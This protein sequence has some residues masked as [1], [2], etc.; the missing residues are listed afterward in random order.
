MNIQEKILRYIE[1]TRNK[2]GTVEELAREL[3]ID[4]SQI[5]DFNDIISKMEKDGRLI[6]TKKG[7]LATPKRLGLILGKLQTNPK[8][9]G[10]L[11]PEDEE[12]K[13][14]GDIFI[15]PDYL[16]GAMNGDKVAVWLLMESTGE[17]RSGEVASIFEHANRKVVGKYQASQNF[18]FVVPL[19]RRLFQDIFI[20]KKNGE[21]I[22]NGQLVEVL[23]TKWGYMNKSP[24]GKIVDV[25]GYEWEPGV[26]MKTV[27]KKYELEEDFP[28]K[29]LE[30]ANAITEDI[31][32]REIARRKDLRDMTLFTID[33]ADA[34]DFDDAVSIKKL[35][36]GNYE[37]GVHIADV[38]HYVKYNSPLD[39]EALDRG[40]SVYLVDRVIPMLPKRLSN[41]VCSLNPNVDRLALTVFME[42]DDKG[43]VKGH[44]IHES[45]INSKERLV[46]DDISDILENDDQ[47]QK[48]RYKHILDDLYAM[49]ELAKILMKRRE[50]RGSIGFDF[51]EAQ[52]DIDEDGKP[53]DIYELERRTANKLIEEFML[54]TNETV[55]EYMYWTETPFLYR[56]HEQPDEEKIEALNRFI[57]NF[58]YR[59]KTTKDI[60][61]REMQILIDKISGK[62][63]E[64]VISMIMLRSLKKARYSVD[65]LGHFG[66]AAEYYTHFT[67][68]IRRYPDLQIHRIIKSFINKKLTEKDVQLLSRTLPD[69]AESTSKAEREAEEAERESKKIKMVDY[70]SERL[71]QEYDGIVVG[72]TGS[73]MFIA[74]K[75]TI[76]GFVP[77]ASMMDDFYEHFE[78][79]YSFVGRR[80]KK[81]YKLGQ[82]VR[83]KVLATDKFSRTITFELIEAK[84]MPEV[85]ELEE[86]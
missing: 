1:D 21:K 27:M 80:T 17:R 23:V 45:V 61:P 31:D 15:S 7:K 8:G 48:E 43:R 26:D 86:V 68:P 18:G 2:I 60:H 79:T 42:I 62:T 16:N 84:E 82:P 49:E 5:R 77:V 20:P 69:I 46:Y 50:S 35:S 14:K 33:G 36:N 78:E 58:G 51:P 55:A 19:D 63:E 3:G 28:E 76:E 65:E 37:L 56:I 22:E 85:E 40:T 11:I 24:E 75:N 12:E 41:G 9:F 47:V 67:S 53:V 39:K 44:E 6:T 54:V 74:L 34:K 64:A 13:S 4:H 59:F 29:V 32:P 83:V 38:T 10:F 71:G 81:T 66:L 57:Y 30:E 25:L 70:M 52:I 72:M 73:G